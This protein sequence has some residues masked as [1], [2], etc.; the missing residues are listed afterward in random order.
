MSAPTARPADAGP[1]R[2]HAPRTVGGAAPPTLYRSLLTTV[3]WAATL[4]VAPT[5]LLLVT[6]YAS[7]VIG[8]EAWITASNQ[9]AVPQVFGTTALEGEACFERASRAE[10]DPCSEVWFTGGPGGGPERRPS[11]YRYFPDLASVPDTATLGA[12]T[13]DLRPVRAALQAGGSAS[14]FVAMGD[15]V[16][17]VVRPQPDG[18]VLVRDVTELLLNRLRIACAA[19]AELRT[20]DTDAHVAG[21]WPDVTGAPV[22][23]A[24][25]DLSPTRRTLTFPSPY[26]GYPSVMGVG[27]FAEGATVVPVFSAAHVAV[28][29][30]G[31][32]AVQSF[33][34]VP[35][36]VML[37]YTN[38]TIVAFLG[39]TAVLIG[40]LAFG[41]RRFADHHLAPL[42]ALARRV[43]DLRAQHPGE[44]AVPEP[45]PAGAPSIEVAR[46]VQAVDG[47]EAQWHRNRELSATLAAE[48]AAAHEATTQ[49]LHEKEVLLREIHHRVKNNLQIISSLLGLQSDQVADEG[50]RRLLTDSVHRVR[51][52]ALI[53]QQL[54]GIESLSR[55]DLAAYAGDLIRSVGTGLAPGAHIHLRGDGET[56]VGIEQAV[57]IGL[58]L[59]ELLTNA[60]KYGRSPG[61]TPDATHAVEVRLSVQGGAFVLTVSDRGPGLPDGFDLQRT[62]SL[63]LELVRS[64]TRQL[65]GEIRARSDGGATFELRV[66]LAADPT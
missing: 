54:Y 32:P 13:A 23:P 11:P 25:E 31:L 53:H 40:A 44:D 38:R 55:I 10:A 59:N 19:E 15:W 56:R 41:L 65:R 21:T 64:L 51:S 60:L 14:G 43:Q 16:A 22:A 37:F 12:R 47:L 46:L 48:Q 45:S 62:R 28:G 29:V 4:L 33:V 66:P 17:Q 35:T 34:S 2:E 6:L 26:A 49:R 7:G 50:A 3:L 42:A 8:G 20:V 9:G 61:G 27:A 1:G 24:E 63:G 18:G 5:L 52:M 57:P 36:D 58:I 39:L 30:P